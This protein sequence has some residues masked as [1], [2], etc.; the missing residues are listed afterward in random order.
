MLGAFSS[1][2]SIRAT[3]DTPAFT[4]FSDCEDDR[5]IGR[6]TSK[7]VL[8]RANMIVKA[9]PA[10][11]APTKPG[12]TAFNT[13]CNSFIFHFLC[14]GRAVLTIHSCSR[15]QFEILFWCA[16]LFPT[17]WCLCL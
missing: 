12:A 3:I 4:A 9:T 13:V 15:L 11:A 17:K 10:A 5:R 14:Q 2:S 1:L 7:R 6:V 8:V 16:V